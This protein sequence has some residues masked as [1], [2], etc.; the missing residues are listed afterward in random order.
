MQLLLVYIRVSSRS[1]F[2]ETP[3]DKNA[4]IIDCSTTTEYNVRRA[5]AVEVALVVNIP[6]KSNNLQTFLRATKPKC[7]Y[8]KYMSRIRVSKRWEKSAVKE[9]MTTESNPH[10]NGLHLFAARLG[11]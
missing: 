1:L 9:K 10:D 2:L 7:I 4:L 6:D 3:F 8:I 11:I 5:D